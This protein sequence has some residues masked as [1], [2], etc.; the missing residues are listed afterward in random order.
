MLIC[1]PEFTLTV[2][3]DEHATPFVEALSV[4]WY[5]YVLV[6]IGVTVIVFAFSPSI[7]F[8][9]VHVGEAVPAIVYQSYVY[10]EVPP[11]AFAINT[12][13]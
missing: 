2:S 8:A 10:G 3:P 7:W 1:G 4:T 9:T 6:D 5:A 11:I 13:L 12:A